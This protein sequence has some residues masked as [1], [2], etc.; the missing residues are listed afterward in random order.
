MG[1][2]LLAVVTGFVIGHFNLMPKNQKVT[3]K[4]ML[5]GLIFLLVIMGAQLGANEQILKDFAKMGWQAF[6]LA[7]GGVLMS[8][9]LVKSAEA[10]IAK[11]LPN[12]SLT[13][14]SNKVGEKQ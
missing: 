1:V 6:L 10:F 11:G 14:H 3:S 12:Y 13:D 5:F 7:A 4:V 8:V 9:L 2:V